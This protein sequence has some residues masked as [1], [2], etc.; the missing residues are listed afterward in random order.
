MQVLSDITEAIRP[1]SGTVRKLYTSNGRQ[2]MYSFS[3]FLNIMARLLSV[4]EFKVDC[5]E[6]VYFF[7]QL[8][9][10]Y[11]KGLALVKVETERKLG[12]VWRIYD[13]AWCLPC[14]LSADVYDEATVYVILSTFSLALSGWMLGRLLWSRFYLLRLWQRKVFAR[15]LRPNFEWY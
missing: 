3:P 8:V 10:N 2:V 9:L 13:Y 5:L 1:D 11:G 12:T 14:G 7:L 4:I 15:R 6:G